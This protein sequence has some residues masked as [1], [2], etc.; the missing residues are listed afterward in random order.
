[1]EYI[2]FWLLHSFT[3]VINVLISFLKKTIKWILWTLLLIFKIWIR[4]NNKS[5]S[6]I[7]SINRFYGSHRL[8]EKT[9][10][11][12]QVFKDSDRLFQNCYGFRDLWRALCS[13]LFWDSSTT[14]FYTY[15]MDLFYP[16][17]R[18]VNKFNSC[19]NFIL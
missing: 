14:T 6:W 11:D 7:Q 16:I 15:L 2:L 4:I 5:H 1:M 18:L 12:L 9:G 17:A 3:S 8:V 10:I 13:F 19:F